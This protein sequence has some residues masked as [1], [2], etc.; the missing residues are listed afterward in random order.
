M[1]MEG[2]LLFLLTEFG[3]T[4]PWSYQKVQDYVAQ[5]LHEMTLNW[6]IYVSCKRV[7]AQKPFEA[8]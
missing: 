2:F 4:D 7:R 8:T 6:H 3:G 5:I 1:G